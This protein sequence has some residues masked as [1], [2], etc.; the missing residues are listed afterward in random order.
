MENKKKICSL[1]DHKE[2]EAI[3]YCQECKI[4]MYK[5]CENYHSKLFDNHYLHKI[6]DNLTEIFTGFCKEEKHYEPLEFFCINHNKLC[7]ASC[8]CKLKDKG[9][10]QHKD[11]DVCII[12][13]IKEEKLNKLKDNINKLEVITNKFDD[14]I[15]KLKESF[16]KINKEK[17]SLKLE[18]Q[19]IFTKI[20]NSLN[21]R[22]DKLL[23]EVDKTFDNLYFKEN[24]IKESENLPKKISLL[25][26]KG[27]NI[28]NK[29]YDNYNSLSLLINDCITIEDN[30]EY[31]NVINENIIKCKKTNN[32]KIIFTLKE[33]NEYNKLI[34]SIEVF[35][36]ICKNI[37]SN[38]LII[39]NN[40]S[41]I[42]S[43]INWLN[44]NQSI[45]TELLYRKSENDDSYNTF[46]KLCDNKGKTLVLIKAKEGF[47][48]G[49]YT[50]LDWDNHSDW[51]SDS[52]TF[53][54]SLTNN[55]KFTKKEKDISIY[56]GNEQG[57]WFPFIGFRE[58]GKQNMSQ[59]EFLYYK[60]KSY[61]NDFNEIIP[62]DNKERFFDV[63]EVEIYKI[64]FE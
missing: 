61:F 12:E 32:Q 29:G 44:P 21:E 58:T 43:L 9:K 50:P 62:N 47:I 59:G 31:I 1:K 24:I 49:G 15:N 16:E 33:E 28:I 5:K 18:I 51:K 10:G 20:R 38:S 56:C 41:Y 11:C 39:N 13:K 60:E 55:K 53:L 42:N 48:F 64:I 17:E 45:E 57:P 7:C 37:F 30:I 22:E 34:N 35:G 6:D 26:E 27:K 25:L 52:E 36:I 8:L 4:Y 23:L 46:H 2:I 63:D 54:F 3:I 14:K 40:Y 19:N